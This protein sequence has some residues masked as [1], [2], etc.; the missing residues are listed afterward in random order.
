MIHL[1]VIA[2]CN[3]EI[4]AAIFFNKGLR[5]LFTAFTALRMDSEN[6]QIG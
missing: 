2:A 3:S 4:P 5:P 1:L 6:R